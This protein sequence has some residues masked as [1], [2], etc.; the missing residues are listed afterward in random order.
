M[1]KFLFAVVISLA[2]VVTAFAQQTWFCSEPGKKLSYVQKDANGKVSGDGFTYQIKDVTTE[3]GKTTITFDVIVFGKNGPAEDPVGCKVWSADGYYHAD[4]RSAMGQYGSAFS[5]KGHGPIIPE[6]PK[7]GE[8]LEKSTITI[9]GLATTADYSNVRITK[10]EN[11][12]TDA[13]TFDCWCVEYT[14]NAK[15]AIIKTE[16]QTEMWIAK[17]V[18]VVREITKDKKGKV[19]RI[20]ELSSIE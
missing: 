9:E 15:V 14:V 19:T 3:N 8:E 6:N 7:I 10:H 2:C 5:V 12:T 20:V 13:G 11:I 17:G 16:T 4:A 1:K 18:G